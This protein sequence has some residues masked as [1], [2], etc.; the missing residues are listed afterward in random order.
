MTIDITRLFARL[1]TVDPHAPG[2]AKCYSASRSEL[3]DDAAKITWENCRRD[4]AARLRELT[5]AAVG[6]DDLTDAII[7]HV[8]A[9]GAWGDRTEVGRWPRTDL[10]A[11]LLQDIASAV[12]EW[13]RA[14]GSEDGYAGDWAMYREKA[15]VGTVSGRLSYDPETDAV[16]YTFGD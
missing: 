11:F 5:D 13:D 10:Y 14:G 4:A 8:A 1:A 15:E 3:G 16:T 7:D 9:F 6:W 12:R 2:T